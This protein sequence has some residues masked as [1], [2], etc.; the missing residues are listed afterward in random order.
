MWAQNSYK[1]DILEYFR[2][3]RHVG[4]Y[5]NDI[6]KNSLIERFLTYLLNGEFDEW[7]TD[8]DYYMLTLLFSKVSS[9][10]HI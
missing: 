8:D 1:G 4:V 10:T 6:M 5:R 2:I 9:I 7:I 3:L